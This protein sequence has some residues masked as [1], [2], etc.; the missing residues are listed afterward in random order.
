MI[1]FENDSIDP[2]LSTFDKII[3]FQKGLGWPCPVSA[4]FKK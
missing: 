3:I 4:A 2:L 1:N